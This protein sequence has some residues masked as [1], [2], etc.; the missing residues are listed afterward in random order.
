MAS[1]KYPPPAALDPLLL[2]H[3]PAISAL[4]ARIA[5]DLPPEWDD[6]WLLR[7][8]LSF[9]DGDECAA[10]VRECVAWRSKNA[11]MLADAAAGRPPPFAEVISQYIFQ[12][13]H[14]ASIY[15]EPVYIVR[16][17]ISSPA[18]VMASVPRDALI[19]WFMYN[20]ELAF[21]CVGLQG[22]GCISY[23]FDYYFRVAVLLQALRS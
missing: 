3:A 20:K 19:S 7:Y 6:I 14:A 8:V 16:G 15:G 13:Y 11:S 4:R 2:S 22:F 23:H 10:K 12:G 5:A 21:L 9:P 17:G 1:D 18:L